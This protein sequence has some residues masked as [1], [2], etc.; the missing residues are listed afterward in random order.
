ML[1][2]L[3]LR[4]LMT[5]LF[6]KTNWLN[7]LLA[8][9]IYAF[10]SYA[11][12]LLAG[13]DDLLSI[14]TFIYWLVVTASTVGYGDYS[15]A[16]PLG[17][18]I[19]TFWVIPMGLS[20]FAL[21]V[22]RVGMYVSDLASRGRRGLKMLD[23]QDHTVIIGWHGNRT[24]R[25][26]NLILDQADNALSRIVL[27]TTEDIENP[28][29]DK[30][31][32]VKTTS[33]SDEEGM[34]RAS[35]PSAKRIIIDTTLDDVT[36]TT[37]LYCHKVNPQAHTTA[38]FQDEKIG[39]L[40]K[41]HCG[42]IECIPSVSIE[43]LAKSAADPGS[44]QLHMQLLDSTYGMTQYSIL[45]QGNSLEL[46]QLF[47]HFKHNLSATLIGVRR[48]GNANIDINPPL[49]GMIDQG[50]CIYYIAEKRLS[51]AQCFS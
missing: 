13:E 26:I 36:L 47:D 10:S 2:F 7:V 12:M 29:P 6:V 30:I 22:A 8:T 31:D 42:S 39:E 48:N 49:S 38:Y 23:I 35:L 18:M 3:K 9:A 51:A 46:K 45:Y 14:T 33:F 34:S 16:T 15:P 44:S 4:R 28:M 11:F 17:R 19:V 24:V 25:L 50:D 40:L 21:V 5:A 1:V 43:M 41:S 27:C 37:A 20:L 32:F